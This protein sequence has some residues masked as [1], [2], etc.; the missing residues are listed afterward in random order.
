MFDK[1]KGLYEM[2]KNAKKIQQE[3]SETKVQAEENGVTVTINL[4]FEIVDLSI[5]EEALNQGK[6]Q[7]QNNILQA[8]KRAYKKAES[9]AQER[10]KQAMP[11]LGNLFS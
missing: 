3:M 1:I 8:H 11:D 2:Q 7:I 10:M 4:K 6:Y 5:S 9:M